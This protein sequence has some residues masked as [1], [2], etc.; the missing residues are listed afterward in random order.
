MTTIPD[1]TNTAL[2]VVDVQNDVVAGAYRRDEVVAN[3]ADLVVRARAAD[4]PVIWVQHSGDE[5]LIEGTK[6]WEY[7]PELPRD[8]SEPLV[9]K[10][11]GDAFED[12]TLESELAHT[13][14]YWRYQ[15][16]PGRT[17]SVVDTVDVTFE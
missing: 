4:A 16:A 2:L 14:L 11:Y 6:G 10:R 7:V 1:R 12:T 3:I 5:G 15:E 13:N 8:E 9:P 17:A